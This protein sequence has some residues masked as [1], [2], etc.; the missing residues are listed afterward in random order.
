MHSQAHT[1]GAQ[2]IPRKNSLLPSCGHDVILLDLPD[3]LAASSHWHLE[4]GS[5]LSGGDAFMRSQSLRARQHEL[6]SWPST[7]RKCCPRWCPH[8]MQLQ[9]PARM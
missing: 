4:A 6:Q 2:L 5:P 9:W 1:W 8:C 7:C 3:W